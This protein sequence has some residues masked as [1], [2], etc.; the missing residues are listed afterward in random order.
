MK[1]DFTFK[2]KLMV[3]EKEALLDSSASEN[4][5]NVDTWKRLGIGRFWLV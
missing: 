2:T 3:A 4:F 5:I 1:I